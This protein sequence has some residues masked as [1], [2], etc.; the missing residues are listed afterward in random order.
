[1]IRKSGKAYYGAEEDLVI[2]KNDKIIIHADT[3]KKYGLTVEVKNNK[4]DE[5]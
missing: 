3:A 2:I 1:M 4:N 5:T